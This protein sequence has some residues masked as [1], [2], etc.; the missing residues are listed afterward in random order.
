MA[1]PVAGTASNL[2]VAVYSFTTGD[3]VAPSPSITVSLEVAGATTALDCSVATTAMSCTNTSASVSLLAGQIFGVQIDSSG[4]ESLE[5][6]VSYQ[7]S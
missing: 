5:V 3:P 1:A 6:N 7:L 2:F 4:A